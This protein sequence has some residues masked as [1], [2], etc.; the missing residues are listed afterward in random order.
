MPEIVEVERLRDQLDK[1]WKNQKIATFVFHAGL[2]KPDKFFQ[3]EADYRGLL[4][5]TISSVTRYGKHLWVQVGDH[6]WHI[7]LN[8][9]GWFLPGNAAAVIVAGKDRI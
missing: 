1:S 5:R 6:G 8:S 4:N 3:D 7:H 9:T 2:K